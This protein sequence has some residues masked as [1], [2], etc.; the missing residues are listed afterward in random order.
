MKPATLP[1]KTAKT[2]G[3]K[4]QRAWGKLREKRKALLVPMQPDQ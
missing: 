3:E 1:K 2:Q 4:N